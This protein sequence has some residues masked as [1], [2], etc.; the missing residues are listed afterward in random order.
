[1]RVG[2]ITPE[3]GHPLLAAASALL[4][5]AGHPVEALDPRTGSAPPRCVADVYLLKSRTPQALALARELEERGAVVVNSAAA[6]ERCQD[7]TAMAE[8][9]LRAGLPFAAT[10][11]VGGLGRWASGHPLTAPV[12]VK[13]R[14]SRRGDLVARVDD[15]A[16]LRAL[17]ARWPDEPVV[18]QDFAPNSGW[19][20]KVWAV[21][22]RVFAA[23]R[24]SEL[25]PGGRGPTRS[26]EPDELPPGWAAL[27]RAAG[28]AYGLEVYGVDLIDA[29]GSPLIVDVNAFPGIRDQAGAPEALAG[30]VLRRA[31]GRDAAPAAG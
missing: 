24:R 21:G 27:V 10:R 28:K 1:M 3:P 26:L 8:I 12:V 9:A 11:T 31:P 20:H 19:D 5:A 6:T 15:A 7:R 2:L 25:S 18:V 22:D 14:H 23:L 4:T 30:L 17:A 16:Q 13:S 29:G